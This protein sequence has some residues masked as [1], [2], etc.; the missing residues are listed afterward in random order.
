LDQ[1]PRSPS[2]PALRLF[3]LALLVLV[4]PSRAWADAPH[5]AAAVQSWI[6]AAARETSVPTTAVRC[7]ATFARVRLSPPGAAPLEV[8]VAEPPG[9]AFR[10]VGRLRVSPILQIDDFRQVPAP[11]REA[12]ERFAEW[13]G[14]HEGEVT[15]HGRVPLPVRLPPSVPRTPWLLPAALLLL[16]VGARGARPARSEVGLALGLGVAALVLRGLLGVWGPHH[17]NGQ[18]PLWVLGATGRP[19]MLQDYGPGY[20]ELF[21]PWTRL[22]PHAPD[23][24]VFAVNALLA[25]LVPVLAF[26]LARGVGMERRHAALAG[27]LLMADPVAIRFAATEAYFPSIIALTTGAALALLAAASRARAGER[28][29]PALLALAGALLAAQAARIH[30]IA[31]APVALTPLIVF[32]LPAPASLR[33]RL[34]R[35]VGAVALVGLVVVVTSGE[36]LRTT[37]D[38]MLAGEVARVRSMPPGFKLAAGLLLAALWQARRRERA[39]AVLAALHLGAWLLTR[40]AYG[41]SRLWQQSFDRLYLLLPLLAAVTLVPAALLR[42]RAVWLGAGAA[43]LVLFALAA[44]PL[45]RARTTEQ[46]EYAWLRPRLAQRP[47]GCRVAHVA[48]AGRRTLL[49]PLYDRPPASA[50]VAFDLREPVEVSA[51]LSEG[52]CI[53]YAR[54][55]LCASARGRPACEA[56]E[57]RLQLEPLDRTT[58]PPRPSYDALG[59]DRAEVETSLWRVTAVTPGM[60]EVPEAT[61]GR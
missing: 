23:Y 57:A 35:V 51:R 49:L 60:V 31:W 3:A 4:L 5:C 37:L 25:A 29:S 1:G 27:V 15:F 40:Q 16:A 26:A 45:V 8:E 6:D 52:G 21:S 17:I 47:P 11:Q 28:L 44:M 59:Y 30:P 22:L 13:L 32:A 34:V 18:G 7:H 24:A 19:H 12:F 2:A 39:L 61:R 43:G 36:A 48:M 46:L 20:A 9:P 14:A 42:R 50:A 33:H 53:W 38:S 10:Q 56:L 54:T 41:Q 55:S 58:F